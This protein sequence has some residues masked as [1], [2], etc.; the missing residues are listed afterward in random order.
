MDRKFD[1]APELFRY[2]AKLT[3]SAYSSRLASVMQTLSVR[4]VGEFMLYSVHD[5]RS[6]PN[7]GRVTCDYAVALQGRIR[8]VEHN[9]GST[10]LEDVTQQELDAFK[11]LLF[12][13]R[14]FNTSAKYL[15]EKMALMASQETFMGKWVCYLGPSLTKSTP[16]EPIIIEWQSR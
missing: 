3:G 11:G 12:T 8:Y 1:S 14:R 2:L 6:L 9:G 7:L 16:D 10:V 4:S 5:L 13:R 15:V